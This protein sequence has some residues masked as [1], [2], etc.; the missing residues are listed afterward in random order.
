MSKVYVVSETGKHNI[1]PALEYGHIEIVLPPSQSQVIFSSGPTVARVKRAL[2]EFSDE[3]YLLFIGDPTAIA[4]M[5]TVAASK[6]HGRFKGRKG[7]KQERRYI[8]IQID[9]FNRGD[10]D[11]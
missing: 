4:I 5:A 7:D 9:L 3:D 10:A 1:S 6:N 11:D 8:P 2:E